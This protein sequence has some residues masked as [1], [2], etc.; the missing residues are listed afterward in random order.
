[1]GAVH[2]WRCLGAVHL[3]AGTRVIALCMALTTD[4]AS[5]KLAQL[6][7]QQLMRIPLFAWVRAYC[8]TTISKI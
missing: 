3:V 2:S 1:M 6:M 7:K 5:P 8:T 4:V